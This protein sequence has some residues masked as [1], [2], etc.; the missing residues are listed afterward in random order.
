MKIHFD[1]IS[2]LHVDTW[3]E[4]FSW[5][6]KATSPYAVIIGDVSRE[7]ADVRPVLQE[8]S[9]HYQMTMFVDGNDE[10][11]WGLDD[12]RTSYET[13]VEDIGKIKDFIFLQDDCLVIDNVAFVGTNGWCSYDFGLGDS[14]QAYMQT[15]N[16]GYNLH[17]KYLC[18]Q[19]NK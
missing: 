8:I 7:R 9:K 18:G 15:A 10:H 2:D 1:L 5:E 17:T 16:S 13:L 11:R 4:E 12:L 19:P 6:G 3:N 14:S